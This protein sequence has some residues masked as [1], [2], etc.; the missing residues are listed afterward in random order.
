MSLTIGKGPFGRAPGHLNFVRQGPAHVLY[1]EDCPRRMRVVV[2]GTVVADTR[3]GKLLHETG[4]LPVLYIPEEDVRTDLLTPTEHQTHCPFKGDAT[5]L[6]LEAEERSE[7][8]AVWC[9]RE[10][11][12]GA[13]P[14]RDHLAFYPKVVDALFEEDEPVMGHLKD[15]YHRV[16]ALRSSRHVAVRVEGKVVA[17]SRRP[18]IVFETGLPPRYYLPADDVDGAFLESSVTQS[19]CAYKGHATYHHVVVSGERHEDAVWTYHQPAPGM[20]SI[21]GHLCFYDEKV[22]VV[23]DGERTSDG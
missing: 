9:Y 12:E 5:Y 2:A 6:S 4:L 8:N 15:P 17:E 11:I 7:A 13:A 21:A 14:I 20:A 1:I 19:T 18:V 22:E 10:P 16:D 3:K 23:V